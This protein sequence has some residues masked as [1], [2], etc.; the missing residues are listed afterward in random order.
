MVTRTTLSCLHREGP[1]GIPGRSAWPSMPQSIACIKLAVKLNYTIGMRGVT[2][3]V[4]LKWCCRDRSF[5]YA[6]LV[7]SA[8]SGYATKVDC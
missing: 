2:S 7:A 3:A 5:V 6:L 8:S 1:P 4:F